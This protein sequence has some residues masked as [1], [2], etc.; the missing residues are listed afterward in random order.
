MSFYRTFLEEELDTPILDDNNSPEI[1]EIEDIVNDQ[2]ANAEEQDDAQA[3]EFGPDDGVD[4]ILDESYI[5]IAEAE[6]E[7]NKIVMSIGIHELNETV[8]GREVIYEAVD[9]KG[10]IKKA[11][12]WVVSFFKKVWSVLQRYAHN[13]ASV[14]KTNK[15]FAD[16]YSTQITNGFQ[17]YKDNRNRK[18][19]LKGYPYPK[20]AF[21][22]IATSDKWKNTS[23]APEM[24]KVTKLAEQIANDA[25]NGNS[26]V[27][28]DTDGVEARVGDYR[29]Y[30]LGSDC[31]A[32]EFADKL[33]N[34]MRGASEKTKEPMDPKYVIEILKFDQT[35]EINKAIKASKEDYKKVIA[36]LNSIERKL[37]G[38]K[39]T[40]SKALGNVIRLIDCFKKI[41]STTQVAR[42]VV[43]K[44][45]RGRAM[46]A[47][48]FGQAYVAASNKDKYR[49]FQKESAE[50]G[51]LSNLNLV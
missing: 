27:T 5:A 12:D 25:K 33:L 50:Y 19:D 38:E 1:K 16:K 3:A 21:D 10:Y 11:K 47:R 29:K 23:K 37:K 30:I 17:N 39:E 13:I 8:A 45:I 49:G 9:I 7:F 46:Q 51:F 40:D 18:I 2:D 31:S 41:L 44:A 35:K 26:T 36:N 24:E 14:F 42:G 34:K 20:A 28:I 32:N 22:D 15:G 48:A 4:D 6:G 43:L